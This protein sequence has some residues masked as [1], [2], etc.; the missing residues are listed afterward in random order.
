MSMVKLYQPAA[1]L[2]SA[3]MD[4]FRPNQNTRI[5]FR[6]M[7]ESGQ[8]VDELAD[9][10]QTQVI[11]HKARASIGNRDAVPLYHHTEENR[12]P[13]WRENLIVETGLSRPPGMDSRYVLEDSRNLWTGIRTGA[14]ETDGDSKLNSNSLAIAVNVAAVIVFVVCGWLAGLNVA[15]DDS[16][17]EASKVDVVAEEERVSHGV[18]ESMAGTRS[19]EEGGQGAGRRGED[20]DRG[21]EEYV[22]TGVEPRARED[23]TRSVP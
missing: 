6:A 20:T 8:L 23:E 9:I 22:R 19:E 5:R 21:S 11:A 17:V 14:V 10:V 12:P 7:M 16:P 15:P 2:E 18:V 3:S 4:W 13:V 1:D